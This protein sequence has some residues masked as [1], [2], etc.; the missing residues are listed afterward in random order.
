MR[1]KDLTPIVFSLP[2]YLLLALVTLACD[3]GR[4]VAIDNQSSQEI[5]LYFGQGDNATRE[6]TIGGRSAVRVTV[7]KKLWKG[8][9]TARTSDGKIL[10]D[11][12]ISW[13]ELQR[14]D[15]ITIPPHQP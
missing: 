11:E 3:P 6:L 10:Y 13:N 2:V 12:D 1:I 8:H 9:I 5:E 7:L 4:T 14:L 15:K